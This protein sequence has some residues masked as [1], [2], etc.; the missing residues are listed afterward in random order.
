MLLTLL[1]AHAAI[2]LGLLA[3]ARWTRSWSFLIGA[4][5]MVAVLAVVA[6]GY[7]QGENAMGGIGLIGP[8]RMDYSRVIPLVEYTA[9]VLSSVLEQR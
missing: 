7:H 4:L 2:G 1:L 5:P 9:R 8:V 6:S 3:T